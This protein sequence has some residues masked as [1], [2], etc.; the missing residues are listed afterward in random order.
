MPKVGTNKREIDSG[1][2]EPITPKSLTQNYAHTL[3]LIVKHQ[4]RPTETIPQ[5]VV[6]L[7]REQSLPISTIEQMQVLFEYATN[8]PPSPKSPFLGCNDLNLDN[9]EEND[10]L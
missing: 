8:T 4:M 5:A 9:L 6:R 1:L 10:S 3:L 7:Y 2:D